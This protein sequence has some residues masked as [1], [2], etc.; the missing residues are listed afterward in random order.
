MNSK[1]IHS[2]QQPM[3]KPNVFFLFEGENS[4]RYVG[5]SRF[6]SE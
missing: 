4:G 2:S 1:Y 3:V 5:I 6:Y